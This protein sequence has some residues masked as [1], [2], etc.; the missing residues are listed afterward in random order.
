MSWFGRNAQAVG[1]GKDVEASGL[2]D[3]CVEEEEAHTLEHPYCGNLACWCHTNVEYHEQVTEF[4]PEVDEEEVEQ[5]Y[6][7]FG[8]VRKS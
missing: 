6:W 4:A 3:E 5:A 1:L 8:L 2:D 7:F